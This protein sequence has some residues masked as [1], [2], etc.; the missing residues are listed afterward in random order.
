MCDN[1]TDEQKPVAKELSVVESTIEVEEI[2][3]STTEVEEIEESI[4]EVEEIKEQSEDTYTDT[5]YNFNSNDS[6]LLAKIAMA[7]AE[8]EDVEGK[9]YVIMVILNR[10]KDDGFPDTVHD[11]IYAKNQFTPISD[12]RFD[13][14]EPNEECW[15]ALRMVM[16]DEWDKSQG[17]LYFE[18]H[19]NSDNWHS[20]NLDYL[21]THGCHKFYK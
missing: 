1:P 13:R 9:A 2:E 14:V 16:V 10:I 17:A 11:V 5:S 3:E 19:K 6:Y 7:E 12:G 20:N 21:F 4:V 15:E 18:S 8:G